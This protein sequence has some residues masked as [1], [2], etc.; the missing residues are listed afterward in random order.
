MK[1]ALFLRQSAINSSYNFQHHWSLFSTYWR[2]TNK[3]IIIINSRWTQNCAGTAPE[4]KQL[5]NSSS[6][7]AVSYTEEDVSY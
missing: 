1:W 6:T 3:I 5:L 7:A 4:K 2:Y